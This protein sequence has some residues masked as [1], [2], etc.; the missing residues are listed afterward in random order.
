ML[1]KAVL[2]REPVAAK[3]D[4]T[5]EELLPRGP[6]GIGP[7]SGLVM[8]AA[9]SPRLATSALAIPRFATTVI[10]E[11]IFMLLTLSSI[12]CV[13]KKRKAERL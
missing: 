2:T 12:I 5:P 9:T 10:V 6:L 1:M 4:F 13:L 8:D 11:I 3:T 7:A